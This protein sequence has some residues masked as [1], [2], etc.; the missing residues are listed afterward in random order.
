M[1]WKFI[2]TS[3]LLL[4]F[5]SGIAQEDIN[6]IARDLLFHDKEIGKIEVSKDGKHIFYQKPSVSDKLFYRTTKSPVHEKEVKFSGN[7][8]SW[9]STFNGNL[10]T[11]IAE[12]TIG[13]VL[14]TSMRTQQPKDLTPFPFNSIKLEHQ[15]AKFLNKI[16]INVDAKD[17]AKNG[18]YLLDFKDGRTKKLGR[19]D[20]YRQVWFDDMFLAVAAMKSNDLGGN[21]IY[22]KSEGQWYEAI[23]YPWDVGMFL[24][25]LQKV[26]SV[27]HDGKTIYATDN[28]E[29]DKNT[30]VAIDSK[31]GE[32]TE[33]AKDEQAD[34]LP[35]A[36][37][38][39]PQNGQ[40][41]AA[42]A[43][44]ADANRHIVDES[45]QADFD[46]LNK[47]MDNT[48]SYVNS[49]A[50]GSLW[51][52]RKLVGGPN[53]YYLYNREQKELTELF[54]DYSHVKNYELATRKAWT[55]K[56]RDGLDLPV[57][58]YLP[59]GLDHDNNGVPTVPLPTVIYVHGGPWAGIVQWNQWYHTRNF[60]L[61]A[62]RGYAVINMEFR[63]SSGMGKMVTDAGDLQWGE[64]MHN[65]IVDVANWA[66][67]NSI[68]YK[69][70]L[71]IWGWSYGGYATNYAMG[72]AP[73]LFKCG[74]SMYGI[75]DL[76]KFCKLEFANN[77]L[78]KN[79][80]GDYQTEQGKTLLQSYSPTTYIENIKN[81]L[82]LTTGSLD[83]RVPK[84]HV[85][86]FA[87]KL[88]EAGK[89]VI[90]F[91]YPEEGHDYVAPESWISFWA[92]AEQFL[93]DNL[94][95]RAQPREDD[96]EQGNFKVMFGEEYISKI[97]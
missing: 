36:A 31:T 13:K 49:S 19:F 50:D 61:L 66:L 20:Q 78:W 30:L 26:I 44:F 82:L 27:S 39:N 95:G 16:A 72:K 11:V 56:T 51:L 41:A 84:E 64:G 68:A 76:Y 23:A 75:A 74:I 42:I 53:Y 80:V 67:E 63:G 92:I 81:P 12:D 89:E 37:T 47:E 1:N 93:Q 90:Y 10:I 70:K 69:G 5:F 29:K 88:S 33:L 46:F 2:F 58:V 94:G 6:L 86:D 34:I 18:Y 8:Q 4:T 52:V 79:R 54:N 48:V 65:D 38:V 17:P 43:L 62:N 21:T 35:F 77:P 73:D 55:V 91:Y 45:Y 83:Q 57:H 97:E 9:E 22:R 15:S 25:G 96:I 59:A 32:K 60:Q 7:I 87:S 3:L 40:V 71:G 28:L 24:G 85:D 14:Y